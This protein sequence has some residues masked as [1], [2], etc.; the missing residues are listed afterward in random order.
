MK[1]LQLA[2]AEILPRWAYMLKR[3]KDM[4]QIDAAFVREYAAA[5][6]LMGVTS[7]E[8]DFARKYV[9]AKFEWF[10]APAEVVRV[11]EEYRAQ[12]AL[13]QHAYYMKSLVACEDDD[14]N[15]LVAPSCRVRAGR[16]LPPG[17]LSG[18]GSP[19]PLA[20]RGNQFSAM[21]DKALDA[22]INTLR[23]EGD[24]GPGLDAALAEQA[25]RASQEK[26]C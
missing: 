14:G 13:E 19:A 12:L 17:D 21:G 10:P 3:A 8:L 7:A 20:L 22:F 25:R 2:L 24:S 23:L 5:L 4:P 1:E 18:D 11:V 9:L 26:P 15:L 6:D 16:L